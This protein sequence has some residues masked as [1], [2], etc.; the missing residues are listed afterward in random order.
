MQGRLLRIR[1]ANLLADEGVKAE[2]QAQGY[3]RY[4]HCNQPVVGG[5][6]IQKQLHERPL[7]LGVVKF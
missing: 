7:G 5:E 3:D 6:Q 4:G 1:L 2:G